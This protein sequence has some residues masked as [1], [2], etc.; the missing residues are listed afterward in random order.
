MRP[1]LKLV[2]PKPGRTPFYQIRGTYLGCHVERS[3]KTGDRATARKALEKIKR[4]IERGE[5]AEK[6]GPT[7]AGAAVKYMNN[8]KERRFMA[9]ILREIGHMKRAEID[10]AVIDD[11]AVRLYPGA[12]PATRNRQVYTPVSA[13]LRDAGQPII[14]KRPKGALGSPRTAWLRPEEAEALLAA[15]WAL[16]ARFGA[17]CTFLLY[18]GCR[19]SEALA[20]D[21]AHVDLPNAFAQLPVTKNGNPRGVHLPPIVVAAIRRALMEHG[22]GYHT[23]PRTAPRTGRVFRLSKAGRIYNLLNEAETA[24]G[25]SIPDGVAFHIFR[26][27]YGAWMR[28]YGGLTRIEET[29]AWSSRAGAAPYDHYDVPAAAR[30]ADLLPG[31]G[32]GLAKGIGAVA[33]ADTRGLSGGKKDCAL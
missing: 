24:S 30:S 26:H 21:T 18:T 13:V 23:K 19:L 20:L 22:P 12:S 5:F 3:A 10:Q 28:R 11:L 31:A 32:A 1:E 14:V 2:P 7:F 17:L 9:P 6:A 15:A 16:H 4:D 8:G 33:E 27:S 25:V 29:G